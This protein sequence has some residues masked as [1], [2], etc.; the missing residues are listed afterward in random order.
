MEYAL[1]ILC[2]EKDKLDQHLTY[3]QTVVDDERF[4]ESTATE[5]E[6]MKTQ[7]RLKTI[8]NAIEKLTE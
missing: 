8:E 1:R 5:C 2:I 4:R 6:I 7:T 3:C